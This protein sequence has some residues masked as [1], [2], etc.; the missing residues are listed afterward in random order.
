MALSKTSV[1]KA[2]EIFK[3]IDP[4]IKGR[5]VEYSRESRLETGRIY[6]KGPK[7]DGGWETIF[8][9]VESITTYQLQRW[10]DL[11]QTVYNTPLETEVDPPLTR[12]GF[13]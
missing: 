12:I 6:G 10:N 9:Y 5:I 3:Q 4:S 2:R 1:K 11:K 13:Y 8:I 7:A